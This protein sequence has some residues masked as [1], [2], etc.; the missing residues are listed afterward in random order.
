MSYL[1]MMATT[2]L[3]VLVS[4]ITFTNA[5]PPN[6]S[7]RCRCG[8]ENHASGRVTGLENVPAGKYPW[9]VYL[10]I[11]RDDGRR[12]GCGGSIINDKY[13]VTAAHCVNGTSRGDQIR[14]YRTDKWTN[15]QALSWTTPLKVKTIKTNPEY[16]YTE[17]PEEVY[18]DIALLELEERLSFDE[19]FSLKQAFSPVCLTR[20]V[21]N[22][23]Y[24]AAG[25]G[26]SSYKP[27]MKNGSPIWGIPYL[28][29]NMFGIPAAPHDS[30]LSE[31]PMRHIHDDDCANFMKEKSHTQT[32][33]MPETKGPCYGYTG[34]P[35]MTRGE[36]RTV[37]QLGV[38]STADCTVSS[39]PETY[40]KVTWANDWILDSTENAIWCTGPPRM[41]QFLYREFH[42]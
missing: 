40:E 7:D 26:H 21:E 36:Y 3:V 18:F 23:N 14:A 35:L 10:N 17:S 34:G 39:K 12:S 13:I 6:V 22:D 24:F 4:L 42:R 38:A 27:V 1:L 9:T 30:D 29:Q 8:I 32:C 20:D 16:N 33:V 2:V 11:Q 15:T 19:K 37:Y 28:F 5:N 25:W 41:T 31:I